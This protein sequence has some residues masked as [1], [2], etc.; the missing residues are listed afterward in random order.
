[1]SYIKY[2]SEATVHL[3]ATKTLHKAKKAV[4]AFLY[5]TTEGDSSLQ[6]AQQ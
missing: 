3:A 2:D 4:H 1:M 5:E 6:S